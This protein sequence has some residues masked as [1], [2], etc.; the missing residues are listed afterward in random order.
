MRLQP[1]LF[2]A[3]C[4]FLFIIRRMYCLELF[5][6][7]LPHL[8]YTGCWTGSAGGSVGI[9]LNRAKILCLRRFRKYRK[10]HGCF[11]HPCAFTIIIFPTM[12][13]PGRLPGEYPCIKYN[14][15]KRRECEQCNQCQNHTYS[16]YKIRPG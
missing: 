10:A 5:W 12:L 8:Q 1:W 14:K 2:S 9:Q 4:T 6:A 13:R 15:S 3:E 16:A 11:C 7:V